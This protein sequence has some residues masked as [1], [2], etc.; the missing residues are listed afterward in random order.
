MIAFSDMMR[1]QIVMPAHLM[2]DNEHSGKNGRNL[3][4]DFSSV[5]Q[6]TGTYTGK[7]RMLF[8]MPKAV[9]CDVLDSMTMMRHA[10]AGGSVCKSPISCHACTSIMLGPSL[11][12]NLAF[13]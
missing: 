10:W 11:A 1:K 2:D 5:A 8:S 9:C 3:F 6:A 12:R 4:K 13:Q 7:V